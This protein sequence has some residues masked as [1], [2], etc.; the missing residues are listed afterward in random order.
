MRERNDYPSQANYRRRDTVEALDFLLPKIFLTTGYTT[1]AHLTAV[2]NKFF[3]FKN[4]SLLQP[5]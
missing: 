5:Y 2:L 4:V 3:I 1:G